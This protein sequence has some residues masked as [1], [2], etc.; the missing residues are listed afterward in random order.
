MCVRVPSRARYKAA[1]SA[2]SGGSRGLQVPRRRPVRATMLV[3]I[4]IIIMV[5]GR[6]FHNGNSE[7]GK[8]R[9]R[10]SITR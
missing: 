1:A 5:K 6:S 7:N 3:M 8:K 10:N 4:K 2:V 9:F